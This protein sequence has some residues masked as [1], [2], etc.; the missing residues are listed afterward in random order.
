MAENR[1]NSCEHFREQLIELLAENKAQP[2]DTTV[3][4][5]LAA[6]SNCRSFW[7]TVNGL[8]AGFAVPDLYTPGLKYRT[9]MRIATEAESVD[10]R[11]L[12]LV[13]PASFVSLLLWFAIPLLL[14]ERVLDYWLGQPWFSL[15]LSL[16]LVTSLGFL[17]SFL[18]LVTLTSG[19]GAEQL[20]GRMKDLLEEFHA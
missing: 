11:F 7:A 18:A 17:V 16:L 1:S 10:K 15:M 3:A 13:V 4:D 2:P 5:H 12:G 19:K 8:Q 14:L 20:K 6:C 9:L